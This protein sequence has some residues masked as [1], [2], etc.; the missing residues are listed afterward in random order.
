MPSYIPFCLHT[1]PYTCTLENT[2]FLKLALISLFSVFLF[3]SHVHINHSPLKS[4]QVI[5]NHFFFSLN[6]VKETIGSGWVS[7]ASMTFICSE[8]RWWVQRGW[9]ASETISRE[10]VLTQMTALLTEVRPSAGTDAI[11]QVLAFSALNTGQGMG[12]VQSWSKRWF[13]LKGEYLPC[14]RQ[15]RGQM[16]LS[17]DGFNFGWNSTWTLC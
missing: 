9:R 11:G 2:T 7:N 10:T 13:F 15:S 14:E 6:R 8:V 1:W 12:A 3:S 17:A 16:W 5:W 4:N